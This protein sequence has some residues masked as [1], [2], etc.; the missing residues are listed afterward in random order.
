MKVL[1]RYITAVH[2]N[3][4][5]SIRHKLR[6][7]FFL[8]CRK[9]QTEALNAILWEYASNKY[10]FL[11]KRDLMRHI[12]PEAMVFMLQEIPVSRIILRRP[13]SGSGAVV[14]IHSTKGEEI[15]VSEHGTPD[16][17]TFTVTGFVG[18][19]REIGLFSGKYDDVELDV[20]QYCPA[21]WEHIQ[22]KPVELFGDIRRRVDAALAGQSA[23]ESEKTPEMSPESRFT[24]TVYVLDEAPP[25]EKVPEE[26]PV[27]EKIMESLEKP[28]ENAVAERL[29]RQERWERQEKA[30]SPGTLDIAEGLERLERLGRPEQPVVFED[31]EEAEE[32]HHNIGEQY[33]TT[34]NM[35]RLTSLLIAVVCSI[36]MFVPFAWQMRNMLSGLMGGWIALAIAFWF[37]ERNNPE[38][39]SLRLYRYAWL[40]LVVFS[41]SMM[42][43]YVISGKMLS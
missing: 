42:L 25:S 11:K 8:C 21:G 22:R 3:I 12:S 35:I 20:K 31:D 30:E 33:L 14:E 6:C 9:A 19:F 39:P 27:A 29:E 38:N 28:G 26:M 32:V 18:F 10:C 34:I 37:I 4:L 24:T 13:A 5:P 7:M 16:P 40:C 36:I 17:V 1:H 15:M 23:E 41:F 2:V 43:S